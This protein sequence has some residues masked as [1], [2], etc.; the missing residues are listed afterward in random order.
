MNFRGQLGNVGVLRPETLSTSSCPNSEKKLEMLH[1]EQGRQ[2]SC[3]NVTAC[4]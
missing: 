3:L 2:I 1:E 4:S